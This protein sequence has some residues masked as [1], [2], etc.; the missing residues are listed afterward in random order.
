[1][2]IVTSIEKNVYCLIGANGLGKST[3]LNSITYCV[4]GAI[5]LPSSEKVFTST[6]EYSRDSTKETRTAD[7]FNGRI[8]EKLRDT[9]KVTVLL[10]CS[11]YRIE[12]SR[13]FFSDG[14]PSFLS[15][16]NLENN[17]IVTYDLK[18]YTPSSLDEIY[19]KKIT[20]ITG[21]KDFNQYIFLFH[22]VS[23][24]D[25]SRSLLLWD[26]DILTN[27]LYIAF[28][29]DPSVAV[30]ADKLQHEM[31]KEDSR[32]RN[33]KFAA[34]QI[35]KQIEDLE[36]LL[37]GN[38]TDDELTR[39]EIKLKHNKL[40]ENLRYAQQRVENKLIEKKD[41]EVKCSELNAR[42]SS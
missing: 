10:E 41:F 34:R 5:P 29:T 35:K 15:F 31:D 39:S 7:Y 24:F 23:V 40:I 26:N 36:K 11:N 37:K 1:P 18:K 19:Q 6:Q 14:K 32:G 42:F 27:A 13:H 25:E 9:S 4:T 21:L 38:H 17:S 3:F 20:E 2:N 12:V 30:E 33:A 22:F 28:G 8:S 16:E